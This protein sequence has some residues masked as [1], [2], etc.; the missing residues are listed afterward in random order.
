M[1]TVLTQ[2]HWICLYFQVFGNR[3]EVF[4]LLVTD[5][6]LSW[7]QNIVAFS[8]M[9]LVTTLTYA[10]ASASKRVFVIGAS[11]LVLGNPVTPTNLGGMFLAILGVLFYNKVIN[12]FIRMTSSQFDYSCVKVCQNTVDQSVVFEKKNLSGKI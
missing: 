7:L 3:Y 12:D 1:C 6:V 5:G 8:V 10:V 4:G 11:L 9:S 2:E